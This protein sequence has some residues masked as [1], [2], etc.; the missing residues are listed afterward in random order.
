MRL[1]LM[2]NYAFIFA[3]GGSKGLPKK[4][5][6]ELAGK[7][8][9]AYAIECSQRVSSINKVFVSTDCKE[10]S[11][12]AIRYGAEVITRPPHLA[13]DHAPEWLA[14]QHA[15]SWVED[16]IGPFNNFISLPATSPLRSVQDVESAI[17]KLEST[18]AD[19]CIGITPSTRNPFFNMVRILENGQLEKFNND[20]SHINRRQDA[21]KC[22]DITTVVYA[23]KTIYIKE[24]KSIF[25][26][27]LVGIEIDRARSIDIDDELDFKLAEF[28]L[29]Y[30]HE[31]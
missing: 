5:I 11:S 1:K 31:K 29:S 10:I 24:A 13:S 12:V 2:L 16:N 28:L 23:A 27:A 3:R 25:D 18:N 20:S 7:P 15:V 9:I 19:I 8:L 14:W 6:K 4:N 26:G 22:F 21:P 17:S 30:E